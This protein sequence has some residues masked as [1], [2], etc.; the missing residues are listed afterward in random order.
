MLIDFDT[1]SSLQFLTRSGKW[2]AIRW[3]STALHYIIRRL[4]RFDTKI[5]KKFLFFWKRGKINVCRLF[6]KVF[7]MKPLRACTYWNV[8]AYIQPAPAFSPVYILSARARDYMREF[9]KCD[10]KIN[11]L[12]SFVKFFFWKWNCFLHLSSC[13]ELFHL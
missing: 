3:I 6:L 4:V 13:F 1:F 12:L 2:L 7:Q 11:F 9:Q 10:M 5:L 8:T